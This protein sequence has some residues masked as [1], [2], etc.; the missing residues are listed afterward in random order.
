PPGALASVPAAGN[1]RATPMPAQ[2]K[3]FHGPMDCGKSTLALQ[4]DH[5]HAR[6]GRHGMRLVR[7][8]RSGGAAITTRVGLTRDA[9]EVTDTTDIRMLVRGRWA[10]G[11]PLDYL[12]V[13][14]A[15]FLTTEHVDQLA[16]LAD[17]LHVDV[18][19]FGLATDFRTQLLPGAKRLFEIADE[20]TPVHVEVLCWCG[21][22]GR[23]NARVVDGRVVREGDTVVVGDTDGADVGYQVLCRTHH[24]RGD[25]GDDL[26]R[27]QLTL[28]V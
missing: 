2:L 20:V 6:Q 21:R 24:R 25:L 11:L 23:L 18:Y 27:G 4:I 15:G 10:A 19:C 9:V 12:I 3:F 1:R 13:D 5:N 16:E 7:Y 8:D 14:E 28:D 22:P 17:D 26:V